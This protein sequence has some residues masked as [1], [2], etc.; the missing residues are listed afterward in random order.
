MSSRSRQSRRGFLGIAAAGAAGGESLALGTGRHEGAPRGAT[1]AVFDVTRFGA[2]GDGRTS[3]TRGLQ[4]AIDACA[5][6]G[7]GTV[8]VPAGRYETGALFLRSHL[9]LHLAHGA[10]LVASPRADEFPPIAG[11]DEGVERTVHASLLTGMD[12][13]NVA[14]TGRGTLDG[15][16]D[17]WDQAYRTTR[18]L[19]E[20]AALPREAENPA[21]SPLKWPRPRVINLIRCRDVYIEGIA[22]REMPCYGVQLVYCE[23]AVVTG[24]STRMRK[25]KGGTTGII[26]DSSR[27]VRIVD[28]SIA[29]GGEGIGIKAGYNEDG[30]R[31]G[32]PAQDILITGCHLSA[33]N[34]TAVA[35]GSETAASIRNVSISNCLIEDSPNGVHVRAPRGRGGVVERIRVDN[36][37]LDRVLKAPI[38]ISHYYDSVKMNAVQAI[39]GRRNPETSPSRLAAV[40]EG[41]PT[42]RSFAFSGVTV[43]G[44]AELVVLVEGLPERPI[45][46]ILLADIDAREA[47]GGISCNLA[48]EVAISNFEVGTLAS[49]AIDAR[50]V[51]RLEVH[52]LR[53]ARPCADAP[54]IWLENVGGALIH[55]CDIGDPGPGYQWLSQQD[56]RDVVVTGNRVPSRRIK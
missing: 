48:A 10:T 2:V 12:L 23:E 20:E 4:R 32:M 50:E 22:V 29:N 28:C 42:F 45:R 31:V 16:Y 47:M 11:R 14:V 41:T 18:K 38:K 3:N 52:R 5:A 15:R 24:I 56:S 39:V 7:G 34:A 40:D 44:P 53:A 33:F 35:I 54:A 37:V 51:E 13:E 9:E 19:R 25:E 17:A 55:A 26:I 1:A 6:A 49:C 43:G 30:R 46:G 8:L 36:L 21:G 27:R